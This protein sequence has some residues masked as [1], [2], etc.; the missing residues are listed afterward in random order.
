MA[1]DVYTLTVAGPGKNARYERNTKSLKFLYFGDQGNPGYTCLSH[2]LIAHETGHA[3]LDGIRPLYLRNSSVQTLAFHEFIGDLTAILLALFNRDIR[4]YLASTTKGD[5]HR[6]TAVADLARQLGEAITGRPYLRS[7]INECTIQCVAGELIPH[8]VSQVLTGAMFEILIAIAEKHMK[9]NLPEVDGEGTEDESGIAAGDEP[10]KA[11]AA[12]DTTKG[13]TA[14]PRQVTAYQA[15]WWAADRFRRVALQPLDLCPPC[16]IQFIDYAQA[17]VRNDILTNPVDHN[18]YR[19]DMLRVFHDR[20][21][22]DCVY[23][24]GDVLPQG[25]RFA[26]VLYESRHMPKIKLVYH[27]VE[28]VSQSPT[29]AYYFLSDNRRALRIPAHQDIVVVGLYDNAKLGAAAERLPREIVLEYLWEEQVTLRND[30]VQG[31]WFGNYNESTMMLQ[32]GGTLVFDNRGNL[33]SWF[34]KPGTEHIS[35]AKAQ[36]LRQKARLT[37]Q[38]RAELSDLREGERRKA[39]LLA[40]QSNRIQHGLVGAAETEEPFGEEMKPSNAVAQNGALQPHVLP[41]LRDT[42]FDEAIRA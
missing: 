34:R 6:A 41:H 22:C 25:C 26:D 30:E 5:L 35:P 10:D 1:D 40:Y 24:G 36:E 16:D 18:G 9:K 19:Q 7:A 17:V 13:E 4:H 2:D 11:A 3:V 42:G 8:T 37:Q 21:L 28:R 39:A 12:E 38:E 29:A 31:L 32:C 14:R 27:D 15:L 20:G 33:L 23:T